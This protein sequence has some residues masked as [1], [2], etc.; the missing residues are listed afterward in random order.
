MEVL[1]NL[2][3]D[4][5]FVVL[6]AIGI[7]AGRVVYLA[8][9]LKAAARSPMFADLRALEEAKRSLDRHKES[10]EEARETLSENLGGARDTL[11]HYK[12]SYDASVTTRKKGIESSMK[13]LDRFDEPLRKAKASQKEALVSGFKDAKKLYKTALPRKTHR[14]HKD[15]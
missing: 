7:F 3:A 4:P 5:L 1:F 10:L 6:L 12:R 13:D 11:R 14:S 15:M 8:K 2:L 9:K